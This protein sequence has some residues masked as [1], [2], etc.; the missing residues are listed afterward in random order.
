MEE[1]RYA[2]AYMRYSSNKKNELSIEYQRKMIEDYCN[3]NNITIFEEYVDEQVSGQTD[4]RK[5]FKRLCD[6]VHNNP[7]WD[8]VLVYD[9]SRFSRNLRHSINNIEDFE[10]VGV[11]V[12]SVT[13]LFGDTNIGKYMRNVTFAQN[14]LYAKE[15]ETRIRDSLF[16]R[17]SQ[18]KHCG[19]KPPLGYDVNDNGNLV[20]NKKEAEIV[21]NIFNMYEYG[22]SYTQM[23]DELNSKGYKNKNGKPFSKS[24]FAGILQQE[25]YVGMYVWNKTDKKDINGR[26]NSRRH[27]DISEQV[28]KTD[29]CPAIIADEQFE[30]VNCIMQK[31]R[32]HNGYNKNRNHYMLSN[33]KILKCAKCGAYMIGARNNSHGREYDVYY[34]PNHK[35]K[36]CS[37]PQIK[38]ENLN[39]LVAGLM[40]GEIYKRK[41]IDLIFKVVR[42]DTE[43]KLMRDEIRGKQTAIDNVL[44]AL[45]KEFS[46]LL[47]KRLRDLQKD[48]ETLEKRYKEH[49]EK[50]KALLKDDKTD[51]LKKLGK[52]LI[53]ST[54]PDVKVLL[55]TTLE[56][57]TID[58]D[59]V[60]IEYKV[61]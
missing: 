37:M 30:R 27:K 29:G 36:K 49:R 4:R 38:A 42:R 10:N 43:G 52:Y 44:N 3:K 16:T 59:D 51:I 32:E 21:K 31:K 13:Q 40:I 9:Y 48:K 60:T 14:E 26:Y 39:K 8:T 50:T 22:Y 61:S 1:K 23:A 25:K 11:E 53:E 57:I 18:M 5:N 45:E 20:I 2:V 41:D 17:A 15:C 35:A 33:L 34:C 12:V 6:D 28:R 7:I 55:K 24:S 56:C 46:S 54:D 58:H 19:G 47:M